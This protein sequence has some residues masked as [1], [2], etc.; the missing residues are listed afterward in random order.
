MT[1]NLIER[2]R[3]EDD[4]KAVPA[5]RDGFAEIIAKVLPFASKLKADMKARS[6]FKGRRVCP[7]L[8]EDGQKHYV[9]ARIARVNGHMHMACD[10]QKCCMRMM[11]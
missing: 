6:I 2:L 5:A 9:H 7:E 10:D 8:H 1:P 11:E 3:S 4:V